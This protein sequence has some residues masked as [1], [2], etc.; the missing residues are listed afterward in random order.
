MT[1]IAA[2][3]ARDAAGA[4]SAH[5]AFTNASTKT[6]KKGNRLSRC[7]SAVCGTIRENMAAAEEHAQSA[8]DAVGDGDWTVAASELAAAEVIVLG[9]IELLDDELEASRPSRPRFSDLIA[10]MRDE[11]TIGERF[12]VCLPDAKLPGDRGSLVEE[13]TLDRALAYFAPSCEPD[14]VR[15]PFHEQYGSQGI[16]Y[17]EDGCIQIDGPVSLHEDIACQNILSAKLDT[18]RTANRGIVGYGTEGAAVVSAASASSD[19]I[20]KRVF[21]TTDINGEII[22][23]E[24]RD[25]VMPGENVSNSQTPGDDVSNSQTLVCPVAVTPEDC[26]SPLPG[27]F[28]VRR[29]IHDDQVIFAAGWILD[30]GALFE[31]SMTLL[32][33]EGQTEVA[34][35]TLEDIESNDYR[36]RIVGQFSRDQSQLGS[37]VG[38]AQGQEPEMKNKELIDSMAPEAFQTDQGEKGLNAVNV[39]VPGEG[40]G[41]G[42]GDDGSA[43]PIQLTVMSLDAPLVHLANAVGTGNDVKFK[44]G[45]ELSKAIN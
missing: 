29:T 3:E 26:P 28:Y 27:L 34:S 9:D 33:D 21:L 42:D 37:L 11:P 19:T 20:G 41:G 8:H 24:D 4:N 25:M 45:A 23:G 16:G 7:E 30:E 13:L 44:A 17:D 2:V 39:K 6:L 36:D 31:N 5:E 22:L 32:F 43:D 38:I 12:T 10:Y 40:A 35:V 18:Y 15:T 14:G 1:A